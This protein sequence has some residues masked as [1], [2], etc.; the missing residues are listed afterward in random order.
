MSSK[1]PSL[2]ISILLHVEGLCKRDATI[3][4]LSARFQVRRYGARSMTLVPAE[5][6]P[7]FRVFLFS[8]PEALRQTAKERQ[9]KTTNSEREK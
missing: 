2:R 3:C 6:P 5:G 4:T 7:S 1:S 8:S 9:M